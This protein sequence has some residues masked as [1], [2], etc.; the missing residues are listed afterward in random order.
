MVK[1]ILIVDDSPVARMIMK[2]CLP[3][4]LGITIIEAKNGQEGVE[5]Y[6]QHQPDLTFM[7]LTMPVMDGFTALSLIKAI[8]PQAVVVVATADI[9]EKVLQRVEDLG[10]LLTLKKPP[11]KQALAD[12][13]KRAK[14]ALAQVRS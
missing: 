11:S 1:S 3:E 7:D 4:S 10:A 13:L 12:A 14:E 2:K 6:Q 9:Q 8:N 5:K